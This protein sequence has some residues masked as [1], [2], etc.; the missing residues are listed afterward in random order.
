MRACDIPQG[1]AL[2]HGIG[3]ACG[4][5]GLAAARAG[6]CRRR[7]LALRAASACWLLVAKHLR[8]LIA[9]ARQ[10]GQ[11]APATVIPLRKFSLRSCVITCIEFLQQS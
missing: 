1:I 3:A 6:R 11:H 2:L 7:L 4:L 9:P 8:F 5:G 10:A